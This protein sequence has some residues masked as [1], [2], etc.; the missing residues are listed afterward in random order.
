MRYQ[1]PRLQELKQ[2]TGS[3]EVEFWATSNADV[4][5]FDDVR[6]LKIGR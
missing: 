4:I 6:L 2:I 1:N 3:F 5:Y